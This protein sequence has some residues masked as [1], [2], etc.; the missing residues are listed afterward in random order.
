MKC[1]AGHC[2]AE[3]CEVKG[4]AGQLFAEQFEV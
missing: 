3:K 4:I 2:I 1:T